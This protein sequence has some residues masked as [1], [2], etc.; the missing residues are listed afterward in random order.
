M[1]RYAIY[2]APSFE[3]PLW[4]AGCEWLGRD[5]R[6]EQHQGLAPSF[7]RDPW[8]YGFHA[9]LKAPVRLKQGLG[10]EDFFQ[11]VKALAQQHQ[12]FAMPPL[13]VALLSNFVALRPVEAL[14]EAHPLRVL[15]DACVRDLDDFRA[16]P[17][18]SEMAKRNPEALS[19]EQ[20]ELL[21]R[22]GYAHVFAHW[23][24]HMTLTDG[25]GDE[26][27]RKALMSRAQEHFGKA[28][29]EPLVCEDLCVF[30]E[31]APGRPFMLTHR[32]AL[33]PS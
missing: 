6:V 23:R 14:D 32:F 27:R 15:A 19:A 20:R 4:Q 21:A 10:A 31:P 3:H 5:A 24:F 9:T 28:L 2:Y 26:A 13:E 17:T 1:T 22:W 8:R 12:A 7:A 11:A 29:A 25:L 18:E 16:A 30:T 33:N